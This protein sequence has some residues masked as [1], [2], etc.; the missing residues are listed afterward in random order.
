MYPA[1]CFCAPLIFF[2]YYFMYPARCFV[3]PWHVLAYPKENVYCRLKTTEPVHTQSLYHALN[4]RTS[5]RMCYIPGVMKI[6][7][8]VLETLHKW[9]TLFH[10][11]AFLYLN[12]CIWFV[13]TLG[14]PMLWPKNHIWRLRGNFSQEQS[15]RIGPQYSVYHVRSAEKR[16]CQL[17]EQESY[18]YTCYRIEYTFRILEKLCWVEELRAWLGWRLFMWPHV[19][20]SHEIQPSGVYHSLHLSWSRNHKLSWFMLIF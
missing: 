20:S 6:H 18:V 17:E 8:S 15:S 10:Q 4:S 3:H 7:L 2:F 13:F 1:R 14:V 16:C 12:V 11:R 19:C 5:G 9:F